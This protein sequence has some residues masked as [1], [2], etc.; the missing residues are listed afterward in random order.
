MSAAMATTSPAPQQTSVHPGLPLR[1]S[2]V[3]LTPKTPP[4][5]AAVA[6]PK[7][8]SVPLKTPS[9][10]P[11]VIVTPSSNSLLKKKRV[12]GK[13][14][15]PR[16]TE[17][18]VSLP[19]G[20]GLHP[21]EVGG[22][23]NVVE[24]TLSTETLSKLGGSDVFIGPRLPDHTHTGPSTSDPASS[25]SPKVARVTPQPKLEKPVALVRPVGADG[26]TAHKTIVTEMKGLTGEPLAGKVQ[27]MPRAGWRPVGGLPDAS[28]DA[29]PALETTESKAEDG[30]RASEKATKP[31][32]PQ[33]P[34][35]TQMKKKH[36]KK[37][38]H[39]TVEESESH[40][41]R[42][43]SRSG[44]TDKA[45]RRSGNYTS[46]DENCEEGNNEKR[47]KRRASQ[48]E[49]KHSR[50]DLGHGHSRRRDS[51]SSSEGQSS[52]LEEDSDFE[53]DRG[54]GKY[55]RSWGGE[56]REAPHRGAQG[57]GAIRQT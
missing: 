4:Q 18:G 24:A 38:R 5:P 26:P 22:T 46:D 37:K 48:H 13:T 57:G 9:F 20:S 35:E 54:R 47:K 23:R 7:P 2:D 32:S 51:Q 1:K 40:R 31:S 11:R 10:L 6:P 3:D 49:R 19:S 55:R 16:E 14:E 8:T 33:P 52:H 41:E 17:P 42:K 36:K 28:L 25:P 29:T 15:R 43:H 34:V 27:Q 21:N 53:S 30:E 39:R 45:K 50:H 44:V 12:A 56:E